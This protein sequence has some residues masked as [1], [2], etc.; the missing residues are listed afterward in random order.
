M[1]DFLKATIDQAKA[2]LAEEGILI[3]TACPALFLPQPGLFPS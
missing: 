1:N 2:G 3:G